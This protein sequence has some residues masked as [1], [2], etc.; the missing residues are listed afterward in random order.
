M[1]DTKILNVM[2]PEI[3]ISYRLHPATLTGGTFDNVPKEAFGAQIYQSSYIVGANGQFQIN[4]TSFDLFVGEQLDIEETL[5]TAQNEKAREKLLQLKAQGYKNAVIPK[6]PQDKSSQPE[7]WPV[8]WRDAVVSSNQELAVAI[9][10]IY[11]TFNSVNF[12]VKNSPQEIER[13]ANRGL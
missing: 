9:S 11:A 8:G 3:R 2:K 4:G 10:K 12:E 1:F 13:V 5:K 6:F 7:I